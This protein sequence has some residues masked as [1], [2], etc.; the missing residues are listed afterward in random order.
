[1]DIQIN[2]FGQIQAE[3]AHDGFRIDYI[4]SGNQIKIVIKSSDVI[5][6]RFQLS[7]KKFL[8]FSLEKPPIYFLYVH[9]T[10]GVWKSQYANIQR[11]SGLFVNF[12]KF[13]YASVKELL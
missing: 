4:P 5:H 12:D 11:K 10:V 3:D 6:K 9:L 2:R 1:M 13:D 8:L 7:L